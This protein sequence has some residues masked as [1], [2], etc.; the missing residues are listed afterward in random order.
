M[1]KGRTT[2]I[3]ERILATVLAFVM[4]VSL[5]PI[6]VFA[7]SPSTLTT[8][9]G[10]KSF[11]V[12]TPTEFTFTTKANDDINTLVKGSFVF[13]DPTAIE[14]L[15]Y[16]ENNDGNWYEFYGEFGLDSGF[17]MSDATSEFRVTFKKVGVFTVSAYIKTASDGTTLCSAENIPVTVNGRST[18]TTNIEDKTFVVGETTEFEFTTMANEDAGIMVLGSFEFSNPE[19]LD[20]LEYKE[21]TN[22]EWYEFYGDFGLDTGFSFTDNV[23]SYFRATFKTAGTYTLH[24]CIKRAGD[25]GEILCFK[26]SSVVVKERAEMSYTKDAIEIKYSDTDKTNDT[27]SDDVSGAEYTYE[28]NNESVVKV[29]AAGILTPVGIGEAT[30]TATRVETVSYVPA[31]AS[32]TVTVVK[33]D[34][35]ELVWA[36]TTPKQIKWNAPDG[37]TNTVTGGSGGGAVSYESDNTDVAEVDADTGVL[38]LKKPGTVKITAT[39][40]GGTLYEDET[41]SYTLTV[42]KSEQ[43][44]LAFAEAN[45]DAIYVGDEYTNAATGGSSDQTIEYEISDDTIA[46]VDANGKVKALKV[47]TGEDYAAV[48][49]TAS[50]AGNDYYDDATDVTYTITIY[51]APQKTPLVFEKGVSGQ[52]IKYGAEYTNAVSGGDT[53]PVT[54]SSSDNTVATVDANGKVTALKAG[55]VTIT[56]KV[57]QSEEYQAQTLSYELVIELAE[58]T[59]S[60]EK[61]NTGIPAITYGDSYQNKATATTDITYSSSDE[62]VAT[63]DANGNLVIKKSGTITVTATAGETEQYEETTDSYTITINKAKQTISFEKGATVE[64][65]FNDNENKF[66]N[67]ASS[68]PTTGDEDDKKDIEVLYSV[69]SGSEFIVDGTFDSA[70]G[71]FEIKGAGTV[72]VTVSFTAN[73]RYA[74]NMASYTVV[75]KKDEQSIA[76]EKDTYDMINGDSSFVAPTASEQGTLFGTENIVYSI[77]KNDDGVVSAIDAATGALTFTNKTGEVTVLATKSADSNYNKTT[78]TY[79]LTVKDAEIGENVFH[80]IIGE[81]I[82]SESEWYTGNVSIKVADGYLISYAEDINSADWKATLEN[83]VT[84]DGVHDVTFY[85][86]HIETGKIYEA[87]TVTIKKDATVPT[88]EIKHENLT[89]WDKVLSIITLGLWE[90]SEMKFTVDYGDASSGVKDENVKYI[91]VEDDTDIMSEAELD[92]VDNWES[93]NKDTG[94]SVAKDKKFVVYTKVTDNAGQHIYATTNGIVFDRTAVPDNNVKLDIVTNNSSGYY[95]KDVEINVTVEDAQ[96]S[97]GI[98]SVSYEVKN[99]ETQTQTGTL[100]QFDIEDPTYAQLVPSWDSADANKNILVDSSKNN[101]DNIKVIV[102]VIDNAGNETK[103]EISLKICINKPTIDVSYFNDPE[104]VDTHENVA[105]YDANRKAKI[106][107]TERTSVFDASDA[108][109]VTVTETKGDTAQG[110]TYEVVD[111]TTTAGETPDEATH[112]YLVYFNGSANYEFSVNYTDIFGNNLTH[113]SNKFVVDHE[114]PTAKVTVAEDNTWTKLLETLTFG[115]WKNEQVTVT[116]DSDDA[117]S[118]IKKL[119]MYRTDSTEI[120]NSTQLDNLYAEGKFVTYAPL[121][122]SE[123]AKFV[124]YI[125]VEDYAGHYDYICSDGFVV[126]TTD[127]VITLT[128]EETTLSHN[129][130]PLYNGDVKVRIDVAE[131]KDDSYS[132]IKEVKY[133]VTCDGTTTQEKALYTFD[134]DMSDYVEE[135]EDVPTYSELLHEFTETVTIDSK[136]NNSCNVVLNVKVT[137]NAGNE[138][139]KSV[140]V[141]IDVTDPTIKVEYDN[142]SPYKT[143]GERG[144]YPAN[145]TATIVISERTGHFE[146]DKATAG[147]KIKAVDSKGEPIVVDEKKLEVNAD[148]YLKDISKLFGTLEWIPNEGQTPDQA[149]HTLVLPYSYDANY[150]FAISYKDL[151]GNINEEVDTSEQKTPYEFTVDKVDPTATIMANAHSWDKLLEVLTFGLYDRIGVDISATSDDVTSPI[152]SVK[153]CKTDATSILSDTDLNAV[154]SWTDITENPTLDITEDEKFV[155]YLKVTDYAGNYLY[156]NADGYIVDKTKARVTLTPEKTELSHNG[157]PLYNEDVDVLI[158]VVEKKDESYSGINEVKYWV[159]CDGITTQEE[160]LYT[161]DYDMSNYVAESENVPTYSELLH[162]FAKTV[163]ISS[164]ENNSCDVV[165]Y[166]EV[167]DNAGNVATESVKVDIDITKPTIDISYDNNSPRKTVGNRGYYPANRTA[168]IVIT[169]RTG[170]FEADKATAGIKIKAVDSKGE[171]I[172]IDKKKLEINADGYLKD[173]S[174]MFKNLEWISNIGQTPDDATH[175]LVLPYVYDA[176]YTFEISYE[177]LAGNANE[178]VDSGSSK[179]PYEFTVDKVQPTGTVKAGEWNPWDKLIETLTFGLWSRDTV[180]VTATRDDATSPI[181]SWDYYKTSDTKAKTVSDLK[182]LASTDWKP[183]ADFSVSPDEQFTVYIRIVDF[184][185]NTTYISTDG[186]IVDHTAPIVEKVAPEI[187]LTA[188]QQPAN[189]IYNKDVRVA[190]KVVDPTING[191]YSGLKEVRYEVY[192]LNTLTQGTGI[193]ED[194][195]ILYSFTKEHP[196]QSELYPVYE[197]DAAILVSSAKNNS[198]EVLVK[199]FATDNSGNTNQAE[200]KLKI[201]ITAP[202]IDVSYDN[203]DGDTAFAD[204]TTDAFFKANRTATIVISERNFNADKVVVKITNSDGIIP[205]LS[206]WKTVNGTGNGD[207]T[208]HTATVTYSADGDYTFDISYID[209]ADNANKPVTYNGLAPQKFTVDKTLPT[210]TVVYDNNDA[211]NG[212]YYKAQRIATITVNEHNFETSRIKITLAATDNGANSALPV[213]S[214]WTSSG[215]VHTATISYANDSLYT[216]DFNYTDKAGNATADIEAQTFYV[217]KTNPAVSITKIVDESANNDEGNIGY[218]ITATDTNFDVFTP[219]LTAVV[220]E[221]NEFKTKKLDIGALS[222]T[223]N[224]KVYTVTNIENDGIYR[225]TSTV[226]DKAGNAYSEVSLVKADGSTYTVNRSGDDTLLTFS[227]NRGGS[228]FELNKNT[229]ELLEKYYVQNVKDDIVVVE[230]NADPL[231]E[232]KVTLNGK[233][234]SENQYKVDH[235]GGGEQ[236]DKYTYTIDKSLFEAEGEYTVVVS[237]KDK[238]TNDAFS[239]VKDAGIK[240]VVD[241]TAPVVTVTGLAKDGRYQTDKQMVTV[242]PTDDGGALKSIVVTLVD[243]DG[244]AVSELLNLSDEDFTKALEDGNGQLTFEVSEGLYQNIRIVC[245]D[246]ADFGTDDNIIYD[247]TITNVSVASSAFLIFWANKPLRWGSIGGVV[248]LSGAIAALTIIKKRKKSV[249]SK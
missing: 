136:K 160:V 105:Y 124:V 92:A 148:G 114:K 71:A 163:T 246:M 129:D 231:K 29:N 237:S 106:V 128:P 46:T 62:D 103:K 44:A 168:T 81:K 180:S 203:N 5:V 210:F 154:T 244:K 7:A 6:S 107:I 28:S 196:T 166:V 79:V 181:E 40:A 63:V 239:D 74:A 75:V 8:D 1:T 17:P 39:K 134:Y 77:D 43:E 65:V 149:T 152:E 170:H 223:T 164:V 230:T 31:S 82:D 207:G 155:V 144:Y 117:T 21:S 204:A 167:T 13:S 234:L 24:S 211:Q 25:G 111:W 130:I 32:Y 201:D 199:V 93:Y 147:I 172:V 11:V 113:T 26:D 19:A 115:L 99:G 68:V 150:T 137:D 193:D 186:V 127:S 161:F 169:E 241:R 50:L 205:E 173:I 233:D 64:V 188:E 126:D 27:L 224:G 217:D 109:V 87:Q 70:T 222:D 36:N 80:T 140:K 121:T 102:T 112:T 179:T 69:A 49:V 191:T 187:T 42:V 67:P 153:Y 208:T 30:I 72:I 249:I 20:K 176:N 108:P 212:N 100:F 202:M 12:G 192:S 236:W 45:P 132:G 33:G 57:P 110:K 139:T 206:G 228:T 133:W 53:T 83:A 185:G 131:K 175:T 182:N 226:V 146:A 159:T 73:E 200:L 34:Q 91:V 59:V 214:N 15:E 141:D 219:V 215:D 119:E 9:I 55:T 96:P 221:G 247:E 151:A 37:F 56:A 97:S 242:V 60:F 162:E 51:R 125:R 86:R 240:F 171:P 104:P 58:Q 85:V 122:V 54:Y 174:K 178:P 89:G 220:K 98:K 177:D 47:P 18:L 94:I 88:A 195:G 118:P 165:L 248:A 52:K 138:D 238:A 120:L 156:I 2:R 209:Q 41:S 101:S 4:L 35:D 197:K 227:V 198:N 38:T 213:V 61:G 229:V 90:P 78:A 143:V 218:V 225:I 145:R 16:K 158:N 235:A 142:N 157:V 23:T 76:F 48:T 189:G 123:D 245:D 116:A 135:G 66:V 3:S 232:Y 95:D 184:A 183:Y 216:F 194:N 84:V 10:E 190:V 22:G 14:K 243:R